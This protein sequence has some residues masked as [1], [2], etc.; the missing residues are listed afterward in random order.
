MKLKSLPWFA[1]GLLLILAAWFGLSLSSSGLT[2]RSW[3]QSGIPMMFIA[4]KTARL[5][6]GVL[7]AHGFAGSKQLMQGYA[8]T[9]ARAG[10]GTLLWDFKG[11]GANSAS[12]DF[13]GLQSDFNSALAAI[14]E[15]PEIDSSKLAVLGHSMGSGA[16]MSAAI[17]LPQ[18]FQATIAISPTGANVT[19]QAPKNL[20]LQ[21]GSWEPRFVD[22]AKKLLQQAGGE[23]KERSLVVISNVEHITILFSHKSQQEALNWLNRAFDRP[24]T[25]N[26][27]DWRMGWYGLHAIG[28][29]VLLKAISLTRPLKPNSLKINFKKA[30]LGLLLAPFVATGITFLASRGGNIDRLGGILVGGAIALWI[31]CA[32][33]T[34][35]GVINKFTRPQLSALFWGFMVFIGLWIGLGG[36]GQIVWVQWLLIPHRLWLWICISSVCL[37]WFLAAAVVQQSASFQQ[38]ILWWLGQTIAAIAGLIVTIVLIPKL[39][40]I[41]LLIPIFPLIF[42]ILSGTAAQFPEPWTNAIASSGLFGWA[43]AAAFPLAS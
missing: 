14:K 17:S 3:E 31:G 5:A 7:I 25:A 29:L 33:L 41:F 19:P 6:P 37:P 42:G 38:R 13:S 27:V 2:V 22:N 32:G 28:W 8:Y 9:F 4:P 26:Y 11:H 1:A 10:Y 34:W 40:F 18:E 30:G 35:L 36:M 24:S 12:L 20:Q 15:Q 16:V 23:G 39:G 43:I 21:A